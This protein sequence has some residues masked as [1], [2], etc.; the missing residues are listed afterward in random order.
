WILLGCWFLGSSFGVKHSALF[1]AVGLGLLVLRAIW[2]Q[3]RHTVAVAAVAVIL[4]ST[5]SVWHVR[6]YRLTGNPAYPEGADLA[7]V[8]F[9]N[10][11]E[12]SLNPLERVG[13]F[14]RYVHGQRQD[15]IFESILPAP[16]GALFGFLFPLMF[17]ADRDRWS[18]DRRAIG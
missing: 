4:A 13:Y 8:A 3:Q 7:A 10:P 2:R 6:T 1:A 14:L 18:G 12:R 15:A 16:A 11:A 5:A 9:K 17:L